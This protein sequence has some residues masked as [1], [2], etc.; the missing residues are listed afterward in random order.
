MFA[1]STE[2]EVADRNPSR[3]KR[4]KDYYAFRFFDR[5]EIVSRDTG[6]KL[7]GENFNYSGLYYP[8]AEVYT[9]EQ[10]KKLFP[11]D[12]TLI[13]NMTNNKYKKAVKTR[14]GNWQP[15]ERGDKVI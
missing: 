14:C 13:T 3:A 4:S 7:A 10:V 8:N 11:R 9:L 15:L 5:E 6:K 1:D 12:E 2:K